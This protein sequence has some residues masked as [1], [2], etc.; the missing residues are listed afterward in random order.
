[1]GDGKM[2]KSKILPTVLTVLVIVILLAVAAFGM[3]QY[4]RQPT[5][6]LE[7]SE[8]KTITDMIGREVEVP[9]EINSVLGTS[10]PTTLMIYMLAPDKLAGWNFMN[11]KAEM[12]YIPDKYRGLPVVGGWFGTQSGNYENF[13]AMDPDVIFEG[14]NTEGDYRNTIYTRQEKFGDIPVV[15]VA[16][17]VNI[18]GIKP[19][20]TFVGRILD[21]E[22]QSEE[23]IS[24]YD[25]MMDIVINRV[26]DIPENERKRV[27]YAEGP[28]GLAT[29]P[30][31]SPHSQ[32]IELCGGINIADCPLKAGYGRTEVSMEEVIRWNPDVIIAGD[33]IFYDKVY[34]DPRWQKI[35]AVK[36]HEVYLTPLYPFCW[37]DRP[38]GTN[39]IIGIP[40]TVKV[41]YPEKFEEIDMRELTKEF[42]SKFYHYEPT[43]EE[44][45]N[46][47]K[48]QPL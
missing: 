28:E 22:E 26:A 11:T 17:T 20:I 25:R 40:W 24:F 48:G 23:L 35:D 47:L 19:S 2:K 37:F 32:L 27:Y 33:P 18:Q 46:L 36:N 16:E 31:G 29:D 10:P 30:K 15:G 9:S 14:F 7:K 44:V 5:D 42:Y 43:D 3:I 12:R 8:A 13:I 34:S 41:L 39:A 38:P 6:N 21:V 1:M 45:S 4:L